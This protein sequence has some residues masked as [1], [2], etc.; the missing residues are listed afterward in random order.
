MNLNNLKRKAF[1]WLEKLQISRKERIAF[2][3]LLG[4]L[5]VLFSMSIFL[6]RSFQYDSAEYEKIVAEFERRSTI[7]QQEEK[8]NAAKYLPQAT[9]EK[10]DEQSSETQVDATDAKMIPDREVTTISILININTANSAELQKLDGIGPSYAQNIID[11]REAN[12]G[13]D[14]IHEL[15]NVKGIGEKR[16]ENIRPFITLRD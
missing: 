9:V 11:Y 2:S 7:I 14:S 13:F 16:L 15:I 8:E 1:F 6:E 3:L 12:G 4:I 10:A 5:V